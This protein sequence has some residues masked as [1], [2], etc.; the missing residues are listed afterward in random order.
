MSTKIKASCY[1]RSN[2]DSDLYLSFLSR[3]C[4]LNDAISPKHRL[5][6][7][8]NLLPISFLESNLAIVGGS[9]QLMRKDCQD[10]PAVR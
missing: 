2:T 7:D 4:L 10:K 9:V 5:L 6:Q 3:L 8:F 1:P